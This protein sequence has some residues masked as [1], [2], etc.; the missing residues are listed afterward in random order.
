MFYRAGGT[1]SYVTLRHITG[2]LD[3]RAGSFVLQGTESA[4]THDDYPFMP[5]TLTYDIG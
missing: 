4:S 3:G 2:T 5:I 1:S